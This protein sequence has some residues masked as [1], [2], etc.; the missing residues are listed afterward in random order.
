MPPSPAPVPAPS[1]RPAT[2]RQIAERA[3]VSQMTVSRALADRPRVAKATRAKI[4]RIAQSL[5][6]RPDPELAKLMHYL[7]RGVRPQFQST[8][9]GLTNWPTDPKP[10]Y[11]RALLA[12]A[13]AQAARRGY[14]F[15]VMALD[16][17]AAPGAGLT[18][19]L[20]SR[21][22]EGVLLLPQQPPRD[23]GAILDWR[24]FSAVAASVSVLGPDVNRV[25]PHHF[26]NTLRLC[27][28]LAALG[29][30][31]IGLVIEQGHEVRVS[32]GFSAA[33]GSHGSRAP[34]EPVTPLVYAGELGAV[35]APWFRRERPDAIVATSEAEARACAR[36][37]G[38]KIPG[39]V[40][41]A[42]TNLDVEP[43]AGPAIGGID[44][45]PAEIGAI[46][47]DVLAGMVERRVRGLPAAATSTLVAGTWRRGRSCPARR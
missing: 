1:D 5:G 35:L 42:S 23:L 44:E 40:A 2:L 31:R 10:P 28:E 15:T 21:G 25:A 36:L 18:R 41:F 29:Y 19:V 3:G 43:G 13:E 20:R 47:V 14:G 45:R 12:G 39:P 24:E 46:T 17:D 8:L 7:R 30:R 6:Y 4:L 9:C 26:A 32:H 27:R 11:F 22:V 16:A 38:L 34:A 33:V 37:L